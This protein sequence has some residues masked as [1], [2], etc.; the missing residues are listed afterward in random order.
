[1][2]EGRHRPAV[3]RRIPLLRGSDELERDA[4]APRPELT[5]S[6]K[7]AAKSAKSDVIVGRGERRPRAICPRQEEPL[8][9]AALFDTASARRLAAY[10]SRAAR[11]FVRR[12]EVTPGAKLSNRQVS[13]LLIARS[14]FTQ[15]NCDRAGIDYC[16]LVPHITRAS[17]LT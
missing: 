9:A 1:M 3:A 6:L 7:R 5:T 15:N 12:N 10:P 11:P 2:E 8:E 16:N 13:G 4:G 14:M 17:S